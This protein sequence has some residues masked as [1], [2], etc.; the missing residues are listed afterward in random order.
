MLFADDLNLI[1]GIIG[2]SLEERKAYFLQVYKYFTNEEVNENIYPKDS[3]IEIFEKSIPFNEAKLT[4]KFDYK[5]KNLKIE[6]LPKANGKEL[7]INQSE[8]EAKVKK[9][10]HKI[11][12]TSIHFA[13]CINK[14]STQ[15]YFHLITKQLKGNYIAFTQ[16]AED[17]GYNSEKKFLYLNSNDPTPMIYLEKELKKIQQ[18]IPD[19]CL[20]LS[21]T[22]EKYYIDFLSY[23]QRYKLYN[24]ISSQKLI[25]HFNSFEYFSFDAVDYNDDSILILQILTKRKESNLII[26]CQINKCEVCQKENISKYNEKIGQFK[27]ED[28]LFYEEKKEKL[29]CICHKEFTENLRSL[30]PFCCGKKYC[31]L[32]LKGRKKCYCNSNLP[33]AL[34]NSLKE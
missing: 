12:G 2:G 34:I 21:Y 27:C 10:F 15:H 25:G 6:E 31:T 14:K 13:I 32:C 4:I 29:C 26:N 30:I 33:Q 11:F 23:F 22:K 1:L 7:E 9:Y 5:E 17:K 20:Y 19:F 3:N 16:D 24:A 28:C 8:N 18:I